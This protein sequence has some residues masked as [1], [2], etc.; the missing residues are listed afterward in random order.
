MKSIERF[1]RAAN[2]G[3]PRS[4]DVVAQL[5]ELEGSV[6]GRTNIANPHWLEIIHYTTRAYDL[7]WFTEDAAVAKL[8]QLYSLYLAQ[9]TAEERS[10]WSNFCRTYP[11]SAA[12]M[13]DLLKRHTGRLSWFDP[14]TADP[15]LPERPKKP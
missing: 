2:L 3:H 13:T 15:P 1:R 9:L 8:D 10:R 12:T 5:L 7:G 4:C 14:K 6:N 11:D